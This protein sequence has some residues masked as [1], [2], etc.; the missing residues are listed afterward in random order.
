MSIAESR[1][2][3]KQ[4][5]AKIPRDTLILSILVLASTLSFGLGYLAGLDSREDESPWPQVV[6]G[7]AEAGTQAVVASQG[8]TKYYYP[9][10][11]GAERISS[12]HK[13]WFP[14]A[15][16]AEAVGYTPASNCDE[17]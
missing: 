15:A 6:G 13:E 17:L 7:G 8:G 1:E 4:F 16:A 14:S 9:W 12:D 3:C 5:L 2:K 11:A 10:C